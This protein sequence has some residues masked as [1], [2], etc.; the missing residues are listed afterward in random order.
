LDEHENNQD[1]IQQPQKIRSDTVPAPLA[2]AIF[3]VLGILI[4]GSFVFAGLSIMQMR[5]NASNSVL[6]LGKNITVAGEAEEEFFESEFEFEYVHFEPREEDI[7]KPDP[8]P[9]PAPEPAPAPPA[10]AP[11][12][13]PR[14]AAP[15]PTPTPDP[16][17]CHVCRAT[18]IVTCTSCNGIGGGRGTPFIDGIP[19]EISPTADVWWCTICE[20]RTTVTCRECNGSGSIIPQ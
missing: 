9:S 20:G 17:P 2:F 6:A 13:T 4:I 3:G 12:P 7:D 19:H 10:P 16:V 1:E 18:G 5:R 11:T 8:T 15:R 14:R